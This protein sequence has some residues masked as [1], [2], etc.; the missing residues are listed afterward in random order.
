MELQEGKRAVFIDTSDEKNS[1]MARFINDKDR[2]VAANSVGWRKS[3][4]TKVGTISTSWQLARFSLVSLIF[5]QDRR[6]FKA[7]SVSPTKFQWKRDQCPTKCLSKR[8][9]ILNGFA[10]IHTWKDQAF[11]LHGLKGFLANSGHFSL[12]RIRSHQGLVKS[13]GYVPPTLVS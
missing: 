3:L 8:N 7:L 13:G 2:A 5:S 10:V 4:M 9:E 12:F 11:I 1:G 6:A